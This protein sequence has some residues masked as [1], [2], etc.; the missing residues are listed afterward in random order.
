MV[1]LPTFIK[2]AWPIV[3]TD[4]FMAAVTDSF[5]SSRLIRE[6]ECDSNCY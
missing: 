1:S 6:G 5:Q 3:G 2:V 4:E